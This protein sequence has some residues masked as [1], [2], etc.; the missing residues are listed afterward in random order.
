MGN[1]KLIFYLRTNHYYTI[2]LIII[3]TFFVIDT[4]K[5]IYRHPEHKRR[6]S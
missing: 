2:F 6:I 1:E 4:N 3:V 5:V